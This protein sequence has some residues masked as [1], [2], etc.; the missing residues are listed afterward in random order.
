MQIIRK[1][2]GTLILT[3]FSL[4]GIVTP[5]LGQ[6]RGRMGMVHPG[7]APLMPRA[8]FVPPMR[9]SSVSGGLTAGRVTGPITNRQSVMSTTSGLNPMMPAGTVQMPGT[10]TNFFTLSGPNNMSLS[11]TMQFMLLQ[12][13]AVNS[14]ISPEITLLFLG[15]RTGISPFGLS[16][17]LPQGMTTLFP[18]GM[19]VTLPPP[20]VN[21]FLLGVN[22]FLLGVNPFL[23]GVTNPFVL[24]A[25]LNA[26]ANMNAAMNMGLRRPVVFVSPTTGLLVSPSMWFLGASGINSLPLVG[27]GSLA[28]GGMTTPAT[29][30]FVVALNSDITLS[31]QEEK[32]FQRKINLVKS[33]TGVSSTTVWSATDLNVLLDDIKAHP[34]RSGREV[35]LS[36]EVLKHINIVPSKSNGNAGLLRNVRPWPELLQASGFKHEREQIETL[37]P[38]LVRQAK[39]GVIHSDSLNALELNLNLMRDQLASMIKDVPDPQYIRAKRFLADLENGMKVLRRPDAASYFTPMYSPKAKNVGELVHYMAKND[40][41]FAP[42]VAGD[43]AAYLA[44]YRALAIYDVSANLQSSGATKTVVAAK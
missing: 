28:A 25:Q 41:R 35:A 36:E 32:E 6:A 39:A 34:D 4:A 9:T 15:I 23:T 18:P 12:Q 2:T 17:L 22:P 10:G 1:R 11:P 19:N 16:P 43:E 40:L 3:F 21:P 14:S 37:I 42:A 7:L 38:E 26:I 30:P 44:F 8:T 24:S 29:M 20:Q 31:P 27:L 33:Q 13:A 5:A